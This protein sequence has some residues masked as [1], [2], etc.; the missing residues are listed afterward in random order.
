MIERLTVTDIWDKK[1]ANEAKKTAA[2][3]FEDPC[4][5]IAA[6][7]S[8]SFL[9]RLINIVMMIVISCLVPE[10]WLVRV[11]PSRTRRGHDP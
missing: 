9:E 7:R 4:L 3:A 11:E 10:K 2:L 1:K 5:C 8:Y 6:R